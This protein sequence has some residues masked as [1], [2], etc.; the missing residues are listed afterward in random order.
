MRNHGKLG[1]LRLGPRWVMAALAVGAIA[2]GMVALAPSAAAVA[3]GRPMGGLSAPQYGFGALERGSVGASARPLARSSYPTPG[4][5]SL[6]YGLTCVSPSDCWAVGG[7]AKSKTEASNEALHFNGKKWTL[8][9]TPDPAGTGRHGQNLL[10]DVACVSASDCWAVG[11]E[12]RGMGAQFNEALHWNGKKWA[13]VAMPEPSTTLQELIGVACSS[14]SD[15]LAVGEYKNGGGVDLNETLRWNGKKWGTSSAPQPGGT[16][17]GDQNLLERVACA[18]RSSCWA[19]GS[20]DTS[21]GSE[22]NQV[23]HWNGRKWTK[24]SIAQPVGS[25]HVLVGVACTSASDCWTVGNYENAAPGSLNEAF[26]WNGKKWTQVSTPSPGGHMAGDENEVAGVFCVSTADCRAVGSSMSG[27]R[28]ATVNQALHWNGKKWSYTATPDPAGVAP[29]HENQLFAVACVSASDCWAGGVA[30]RSSGGTVRSE[31]L[32]WNGKRWTA[33]WG[34][35][36][37]MPEMASGRESV[38]ASW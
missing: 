27:T 14:A 31:I 26:R 33:G 29:G 25:N 36:S 28:A 18:S 22:Q 11:T 19:A 16:T 9:A 17:S 5:A 35:Q 7:Y 34:L 37:R 15:C 4:H 3:G 23:L 10:Y 1:W 13:G 32:H 20:Y 24:S 38:G 8:V 12:E 21:F 30:Q 2:M 6:T